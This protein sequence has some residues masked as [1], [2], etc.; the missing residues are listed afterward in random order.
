MN[1]NRIG[2]EM[3]LNGYNEANKKMSDFL[4][5]T[6]EVE[7]KKVVEINLK[8]MDKAISDYEKLGNEADNILKK[9]SQLDGRSKAFK[10]LG[11]E[12]NRVL[13][14]MTKIK[15]GVEEV[16]GTLHKSVLSG[17][18]NTRK[19]EK[20]FESAMD[21]KV[22]KAKETEKKIAQAQ[23][24]K[25]K[26]E[27]Y[28]KQ[29]ESTKKEAEKELD[30]WQDAYRKVERAKNDILNGKKVTPSEFSF[31]LK[32]LELSEEKLN[33]LIGDM[34]KFSGKWK[35]ATNEVK[36]FNQ[37]LSDGMQFTRDNTIETNA[38]D[39]LQILEK[40]WEG[41]A[42]KKQ[43]YTNKLGEDAIIVKEISQQQDVLNQKMEEYRQVLIKALE[44]KRNEPNAD[45]EGINAAIRKIEL[46]REQFQV[47]Q[48]NIQ[49]GNQELQQFNDVK[50]KVN[51]IANLENKLTQLTTNSP[52]KHSSEIKYVRELLDKKKQ[53]YNI[54]EAIAKLAPSQQKAIREI[55][56]KNKE[57]NNLIK[58]HQKDLENNNKTL[59]D[60]L[61][62]FARFTL[63]YTVLQNMKNLVNQMLTTMKEL[64]KA[65]TDIQLVTGDTKEGTAQLAKEYNQL[66]KEMGATTLEVAE[67]AG[68][69]LR[70]GKT[71]E[72]TTELLKASMTLSK[73]GA[74][75]SSQATELLTSSLNG[76]KLEAQDAISVVDKISS[77]DLAAATSSYELA[78][79][80]SRTANS[81]NDAN[82]SFD[83]LLAMIGTTS[84]VTRKSAETIR[85]IL[86]N[87]ICSYEQCCS[88]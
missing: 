6:K 4:T 54:E 82:V 60:T 52:S 56:A 78:T 58:V 25:E 19:L 2:I 81:A 13:D 51:E 69:W 16:G 14:T 31:L 72:E 85:R 71:T 26:S 3:I 44:L 1:N 67:G 59:G 68:E 83:K 39:S 77:I 18:D 53:Q 48:Q 66:A 50:N 49:L 27:D 28:Q 32:T 40:D 22:K 64:D 47:K 5:V 34:G 73:V 15:S 37:R 21:K 43:E 88:W 17:I 65:F 74:I 36:Q 84:S 75:E 62:N 35:G 30:I 24:R 86:Q 42:K 63:Y 7:G 8:G 79:A 55:I 11:Q 38:R 87:N 70:Q 45:K 41:L 61:K 76:Y 9:M 57:N 33:N 12:L 29:F 80:L 46:E 10:D 20:E 23:A